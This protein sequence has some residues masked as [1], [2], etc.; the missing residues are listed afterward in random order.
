MG[1]KLVT[2]PNKASPEDAETTVASMFRRRTEPQRSTTAPAAAVPDRGAPKG[3][4]DFG[5]GP[6][7]A[8]QHRNPDGSLG[9]WVADTAHVADTAFVGVNA[10]VSGNARVFGVVF[11]AD[12]AAVRGN[13]RVDDDA[14][15]KDRAVITGN[16]KVS[17]ACIF[18]D[19]VVSG[20]ARVA[21]ESLIG[22]RSRVDGEARVIG[23]A[24]LYDDARV[25]GR[26]WVSGGMIRGTAVV[27]GSMVV[28]EG[29]TV[30][31]PEPE[32]KATPSLEVA[33][34][35]EVEMNPT[36]VEDEVEDPTTNDEP[37]ADATRKVEP[38]PRAKGKPRAKAKPRGAAAKARVASE[39]AER[40]ERE[41]LGIDEL[42]DETMAGA[43]AG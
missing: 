24:Q 27:D 1:R 10:T 15:I 14:V 23:P 8:R 6:V 4:F 37:P 26:A 11:I 40:A 29:M 16:S 31:A 41:T 34:V 28:R 17:N 19:A 35:A 20:E 2:R 39:S 33:E 5:S 36:D 9:G 13:A 21:G 43:H 7:P 30:G 18:D 12:E 22:Q 25:T 32:R 38:R 3:R 42:I